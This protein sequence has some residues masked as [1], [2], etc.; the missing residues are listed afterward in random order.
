MH[1]FHART[2]LPFFY[3][4]RLISVLT[5][6]DTIMLH[7]SVHVV[8]VYLV[9]VSLIRYV[10]TMLLRAFIP[11]PNSSYGFDLRD[12]PSSCQQQLFSLPIKFES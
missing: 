2:F 4:M 3:P 8:V 12:T 10:S 9:I 1:T 11:L 5:Y 6:L 7:R